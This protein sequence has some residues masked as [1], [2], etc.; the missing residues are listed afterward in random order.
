MVEIQECCGERLLETDISQLAHCVA[1]ELGFEHPEPG[2][3]YLQTLRCTLRT[4]REIRGCLIGRRVA[5]IS[6]GE[7]L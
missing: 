6:D 2:S 5:I 3:R 4:K 7:V 1:A